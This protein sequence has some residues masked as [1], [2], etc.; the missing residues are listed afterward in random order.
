MLPPSRASRRAR[1]RYQRARCSDSVRASHTTRIGCRMLRSNVMVAYSPPNVTVPPPDGRPAVIWIWPPCAARG[2]SERGIIKP[3]LVSPVGMLSRARSSSF[4][5][6][7]LF[8]GGPGVKVPFQGLERVGPHRLI[9]RDPFVELGE[10]LRLDRVNPLLRADGDID[11]LG[12]TEHLQVLRDT[13]LGEARKPRGDSPGGPASAR[14]KVQDR[15]A[16]RV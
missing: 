15:P 1:V 10:A 16:G 2:D 13:R 7:S 6:P 14:K 8:T 5:P 11:E 9:L 3:P 12:V 4:L